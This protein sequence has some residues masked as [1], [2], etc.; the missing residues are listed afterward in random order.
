[1]MFE[2][3]N[4]VAALHAITCSDS[5]ITSALFLCKRPVGFEDERDGLDPPDV[6]TR[7]DGGRRLASATKPR[8]SNSRRLGSPSFHQRTATVCWPSWISWSCRLADGKGPPG[9]VPMFLA[10]PRTELS[11]GS[12]F[13]ACELWPASCFQAPFSRR[14][15]SVLR[16][17]LA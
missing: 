12:Y 4:E 5:R 6:S 17:V 16:T 13:A 7:L 3:P 8:G 10:S 15:V 9:T 14:N 2:V 1:M 11:C